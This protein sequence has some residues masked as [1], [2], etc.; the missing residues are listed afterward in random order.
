MA[1]CFKTAIENM[2]GT[3]VR[4]Q[5]LQLLERN[6]IPR[7]EI[8]PRFGEVVRVL[9]VAFGNSSRLL[10]YRTVVELYEEYSVRPTFGFYD[11]LGDQLVLLKSRVLTDLLK[12]QHAAKVDDSIYMTRPKQDD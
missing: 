11:S 6:N 3:A 7:S 1:L 2:M 12:P 10:I 9:T 4:E 5:V 8:A